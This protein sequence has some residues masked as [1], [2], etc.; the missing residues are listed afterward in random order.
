M[1]VPVGTCTSC[2]A[3]SVFCTFCPPL[4][5]DRHVDHSRSFARSSISAARASSSTATVIV[6]A[7]T[8]PRFSAGGIRCHLWPPASPSNRARAPLPVTRRIAMPGRSSSTSALKK[9]PAPELEV[10][11]E[12][13]DHEQ[14]GVCAIFGGTDL[15]DD[16]FRRHDFVPF[17]T[18]S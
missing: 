1:C 3:E 13:F 5:V 14:L 9:P 2:T 10:N 16:R 4:P 18:R 8:R 11:R 12:L 15:D 6:L 7:C 17:S